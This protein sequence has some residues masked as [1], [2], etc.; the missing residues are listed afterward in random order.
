VKAE[1]ELPGFPPKGGPK[2]ATRRL[3]VNIEEELAECLRCI[4]DAAIRFNEIIDRP[5][6]GADAD[7]R[8]KRAREAAEERLNE[9]ILKH[10]GYGGLVEMRRALAVIAPPLEEQD[11]ERLARSPVRWEEVKRDM[12]Y[13]EVML[14]ALCLFYAVR[15][16]KPD[17]TAGIDMRSGNR[18]SP[19][20]ERAIRALPELDEKRRGTWALLILEL[21]VSGKY[22]T[23][24]AALNAGG[25]LYESIAARAMR[26]RQGKRVR[27]FKSRYALPQI[28]ARGEWRGEWR[29]IA[30]VDF[31][32]LAD[33]KKGEVVDRSSR[34]GE[35][36]LI[37]RK[38]KTAVDR[39]KKIAE[40]KASPAEI[41]S[42]LFVEIQDRLMT[43]P[44]K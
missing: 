26:N 31:L 17:W 3:R 5:P 15:S 9:S 27:D 24:S 38:L 20:E 29:G 35:D 33:A 34:A 39:A 16:P 12:F 10:V 14:P 32:K 30:P 8:A 1:G 25:K 11:K 28:D 40:M 2:T 22:W 4:R 13:L 18:V 41:R 6:L 19:E 21:T 36:P 42:E 7:E 37:G 43:I 44:R 23:I